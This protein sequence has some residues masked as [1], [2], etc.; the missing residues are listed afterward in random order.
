VTFPSKLIDQSVFHF[1][2]ES[3]E[4]CVSLD[5]GVIVGLIRFRLRRSP[6]HRLPD[7]PRGVFLLFLHTTGD[8][9]LIRLGRNMK[10]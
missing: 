8:H 5:D 6:A 4:L 3:M 2:N 1:Y 7:D 9:S 10:C